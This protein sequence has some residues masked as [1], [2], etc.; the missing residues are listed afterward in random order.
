M[1]TK[2]NTITVG[3]LVALSA[4]LIAGMALWLGPQESDTT[5]ADESQ[6]NNELLTTGPLSPEELAAYETTMTNENN[7]KAVITTNRGTFTLELFEDTMP[8]TAGNFIKLAEEGFYNGIKFHRVIEGFMIQGGDPITKTDEYLRYGTGGPGYTIPDEHV[9]G[10]YLTNVRGSIAMANRGPESGGSQFFIN[11]ADN[12]GLDFDKAPAS[13]KH[14]V[15]GHVVAGMDVVDAIALTP[16]ND[17]DMPLEAVV[18]ESV[19][20]VR[21]S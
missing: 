13:S 9:A 14:P 16:V 19:E 15:F 3:I 6:K 8:I 4:A 10:K 7:P 18:I 5:T 20:I 21:P 17:N 11:V 1:V 2:S 12:L